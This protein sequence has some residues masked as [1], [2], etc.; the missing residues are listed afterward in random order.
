MLLGSSGLRQDDDAADDQPADRADVGQA[1]GSTARTCCRSRRTSCAGGSATSSSR[2]ACS[3]TAPCSTTSRRCPGCSVG[4]SAAATAAGWSCS[5][6]SASIR[7][8]PRSIP[9]QLSGGQQQRVG[10]ARALAADPNILLDGRALRRRRPDRPGPAAA[11]VPQAAARG[12]QDGRVRH[13]RRRRGDPRR[14]ADRRDEVAWTHHPDRQPGRSA[15][16][17]R[18]RLRSR[19]RRAPRGGLRRAPARRRDTRWRPASTR[20]AGD[21]RRPDL[22]RQAARRQLGRH[23]VLRAAARAV[24]RDRGRHRHAAVDPAVAPRRASAEDVPGVARGDER[25]LRDPLGRALRDPVAGAR[26]HERQ[27]DRRRR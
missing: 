15:R 12:E 4:T 14:H 23:L 2:V 13:P 6:S 9:A 27:A 3:R 26:L 19:L 21:R 10:V 5:S 18:R 25:D 22:E 20:P 11:R 24:H 1:S 8:A 16:R 7:R 17:P